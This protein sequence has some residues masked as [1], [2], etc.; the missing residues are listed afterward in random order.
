MKIATTAISKRQCASFIHTRGKKCKTFFI[1]KNPDI[2]QKARQFAFR[3]YIEKARKFT[4][5]DFS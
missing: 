5:C 3:C 2:S 4:L 1:Y